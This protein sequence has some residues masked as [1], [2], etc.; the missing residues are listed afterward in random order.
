MP[1]ALFKASGIE[2]APRLALPNASLEQTLSHL[3][4]SPLG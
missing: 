2:E 3:L 4:G 1:N